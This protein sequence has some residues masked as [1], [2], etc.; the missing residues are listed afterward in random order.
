MG[1]KHP[2]MASK[3][4]EQDGSAEF[5][6]KLALCK[7]RIDFT[8]HLPY[9]LARTAN[10]MREATVPKYLRIIQDI[11]PLA[12]RELRILVLLGE[13]S[14]LSPAKAAE[15]TGMDRGTVSRAILALK[16]HRLVDT[17][18]NARDG[19]GKYIVPTG[20]GA[21]LCDRI[22]PMMRDHGKFLTETFSAKEFDL[23]QGLLEKI[24]LR[25][26]LLSAK[27]CP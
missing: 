12:V 9:R 22:I 27:E 10:L 17:L 7:E 6:G 21:S 23:L 16:N 3:N 4:R 13:Y 15:L 19:R 2:T 5:A 18:K 24:S 25:A 20:K 1:T 11:A 14:P 26:Q 8:Q